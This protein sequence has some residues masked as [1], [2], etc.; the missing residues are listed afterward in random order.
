MRVP[1]LLKLVVFSEEFDDLK[2][3]FA[4]PQFNSLALSP[5]WKATYIYSCSWI[6]TAWNLDPIRIVIPFKDQT[7]ATILKNQRKDLS[8][9]IRINVQQALVSKGIEQELKVP[10]S[11]KWFFTDSDRAK[12]KLFKKFYIRVCI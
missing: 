12:K 1:P 4:R 9:K 7:S 5:W 3:M 10:I 11:S 6:Y 8:N 2:L